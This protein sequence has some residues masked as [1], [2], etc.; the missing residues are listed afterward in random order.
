MPQGLVVDAPADPLRHTLNFWLSVCAKM[1]CLVSRVK[2]PPSEFAAICG[3]KMDVI[4]A[5][6]WGPKIGS[7]WGP[8][9]GSNLDSI[10]E[11]RLGP[12]GQLTLSVSLSEDRKNI[13][14]YIKWFVQGSESKN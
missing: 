9:T 14:L 7:I 13:S 6:I 8:K 3:S 12:H 5:S 10:L 4:L 2:T 1:L 11:P